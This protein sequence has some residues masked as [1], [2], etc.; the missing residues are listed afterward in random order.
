MTHFTPSRSWSSLR[1]KERSKAQSPAV[2]TAHIPGGTRRD[3]YRLAIAGT[4]A[5]ALL[6]GLLSGRQARTALRDSEPPAAAISAP[7]VRLAVLAPA[8]RPAAD[9]AAR[10]SYALRGADSTE[11]L[12]A[13]REASLS[14]DEHLI[15][16]AGRLLG[17]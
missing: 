10:A 15:A 1:H 4:L 8:L 3:R 16:E 5:G 11:R 6:S 17:V 7:A 12:C 14:A 13:A 2:R 9:A